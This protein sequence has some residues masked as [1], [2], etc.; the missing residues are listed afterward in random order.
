VVFF[1][2]KHGGKNVKYLV[3]TN[4]KEMSKKAADIVIKRLQEKENLV[5]G[6]P[7]GSTPI[8]IYKELVKDFKQNH[9]SYERARSINIDEYIKLSKDNPNSYMYYMNHH[10]FSHINMKKENI[11]IP[12]GKTDN[13]YDECYRYDQVIETIGPID[14]LILGIGHNGHIGFNEPG[15]SFDSTTHMVELTEETRRMN[16]R[17]FLSLD[18]VPKA[19]ITM[20]L[21]TMMESKE[22]ILLVTGDGKSKAYERLLKNEISID[23]PASVLHEH[24]NVTAIID[25]N[26][27]HISK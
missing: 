12:N 26:T 17:H 4:Y 8:G 21:K 10:F 18:K 2:Q 6:L 11:H 27:I 22:I 25:Q 5:L 15:T 23:F 20:G 24:P 19:A 16:A 1:Y 7:T 3:A 13:V 14:L 9:T